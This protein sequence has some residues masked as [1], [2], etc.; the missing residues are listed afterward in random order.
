MK[1][2]LFV[3][4]GNIC[5]SVFAEYLGRSV[6]GDEVAFES[7]GIRAQRA[8]DGNTTLSLMTSFSIDA[9]K[10]V[11]RDVRTLDLEQYDLIIALDRAAARQLED[12]GVPTPKMLLWKIRDP[13]GGDLAEYDRAAL[14]VKHRLFQLDAKGL[15]APS[16]HSHH[17]PG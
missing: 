9:S 10:H 13:W 7:A 12:M 4:I 16:E 1:R 5:R 17:E 2:V 14:D 11:P 15:D 6:F 8:P 3:C